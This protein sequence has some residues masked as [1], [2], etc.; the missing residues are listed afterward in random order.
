MPIDRSQGEQRCVECGCTCCCWAC[1]WPDVRKL[2]NDGN[3]V[4]WVKQ[5]AVA[6]GCDPDT[7]ELDDWYTA[8]ADGNVWMGTCVDANSGDTREL[9]I[10]VD[11]GVTTSQV[12]SSET[13]DSGVTSSDNVEANA[14]RATATAQEAAME[15]TASPKRKPAPAAEGLL[16]PDQL[17][18]HLV[19]Q[20]LSG[21]H[22]PDRRSWEGEP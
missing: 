18:K 5:Q 10:N 21:A 16:T 4:E 22:Y 12:A 20:H 11:G 13:V 1:S 2:L 8:T 7:L 3:L 9:A 6:A 17:K 14:D 19:Q 15:P